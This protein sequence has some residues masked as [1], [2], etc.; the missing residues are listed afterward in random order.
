LFKVS[1]PKWE[2]IAQ[3]RV[4]APSVDSARHD[5]CHT[6]LAVVFRAVE[7]PFVKPQGQAR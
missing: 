6:A 1:K 3:P 4:T 2:P 5:P 7:T